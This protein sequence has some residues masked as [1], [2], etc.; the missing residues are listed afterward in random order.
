MFFLLSAPA[1]WLATDH[2]DF[3]GSNEP[4]ERSCGLD[5]KHV[6]ALSQ[7]AGLSVC[8]DSTNP[9][10]RRTNDSH[11][12]ESGIHLIL[13]P[14]RRTICSKLYTFCERAD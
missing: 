6:R 13:D 2:L 3:G 11:D 1:G 4:V 9:H 12:L 8:L 7:L 10:T 5:G 14:Q